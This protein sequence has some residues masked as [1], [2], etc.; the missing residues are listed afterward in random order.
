MALWLCKK[1]CPQVLEV[2]TE[3]CKGE[4]TNYL[5][6]AFK[7]FQKN[8]DNAGIAKYFKLLNLSDTW[9]FIIL[10]SLFWGLFEMFYY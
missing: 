2:D 5:G 4:V 1:K 9:K 8:T 3:V 10:F 6:F 7:L